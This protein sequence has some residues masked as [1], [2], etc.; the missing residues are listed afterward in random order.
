M[1]VLSSSLRTPDPSL[2]RDAW[3]SYQSAQEMTLSRVSSI[4]ADLENPTMEKTDGLKDVCVLNH[5]QVFVTP[6][7]IP[8]QAPLSLDFCG[9]E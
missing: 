7:T 2:L 6:W 9:Q 3:T 5:V 1:F 4:S 8:H